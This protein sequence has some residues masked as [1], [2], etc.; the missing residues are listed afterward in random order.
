MDSQ[1]SLCSLTHTTPS[2]HTQPNHAHTAVSE[3]DDGGDGDVDDGGHGTDSE[4]PETTPGSAD[5][6]SAGMAAADMTIVG[7]GD[8]VVHGESGSTDPIRS[9]LIGYCP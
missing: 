1:N 3:A 4:M 5:A 8:S 2:T 7:V 6:T 9:V